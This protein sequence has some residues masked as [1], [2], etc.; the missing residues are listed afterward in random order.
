MSTDLPCVEHISSQHRPSDG[1]CIVEDPRSCTVHN[2]LQHDHRYS[3]TSPQVEYCPPT[4]GGKH[5]F[6]YSSI[7]GDNAAVIDDAN[8]LKKCRDS[9]AKLG[10][11]KAKAFVFR[12]TVGKTKCW[13]KS[14]LYGEKFYQAHVEKYGFSLYG[15]AQNKLNSVPTNGEIWGRCAMTLYDTGLTAWEYFLIKQPLSNCDQKNLDEPYMLY[16]YVTSVKECRKAAQVLGLTI[17]QKNGTLLPEVAD[18]VVFCGTNKGAGEVHMI[19]EAYQEANPDNVKHLTT[20]TNW[21][22]CRKAPNCHMEL[23][24]KPVHRGRKFLGSKIKT[25]RAKT[26][27]ECYDECKNH[28][29]CGSVSL[30]VSEGSCKLIKQPKGTRQTEDPDIM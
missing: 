8:T 1:S 27:K 14:S 18:R 22:V 6:R 3:P 30:G 11:S 19:S 9:C 26:L 28:R 17:P 15:G 16:E 2:L 5:V 10:P 25:L 21:M 12:P 20:A 24:N 13:C 4:L 29:G 23:D 7:H